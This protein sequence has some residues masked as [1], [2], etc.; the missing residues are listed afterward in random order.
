MKK[1]ISVLLVL[2]MLFSLA[3]CNGKDVSNTA[4]EAKES[5]EASET[6]EDSVIAT[7]IAKPVEIEF[8]HA[9]SGGNEEALKE[10]VEDFNKQN[11]KVTVK[12]VYQGHYKELFQKLTGAA[13]AGQ[14][15]VLTQIFPNRMTA[16]VMN[17]L[18][19][20]LTPY[21]NNEKVGFTEEDLKD[22]PNVFKKGIW[23]GKFYT[24]PCNKSAYLLFYN[25]DILDKYDVEVPTTWDELRTAAEKLTVDTDGDGKSDIIGV[26][27]NKS[28]G[29]D[30]SFWVEQ[31]GGHLI[32][33]DE[34]TITFNSEAGVEAFDF[35]S[36]MVKDGVA[37]VAGEEKYS[38]VPFA[39]GEAAMMVS[40][41]SKL[42][43][44]E[45][46]IGDNNIQWKAAV[47]PKGKKQAALFSGTDMA[48][49]NTHSPE[50]KLA[51]WEFMKYFMSKDATIKWGKNSGYLPVRYSAL[52]SE[53]FKNYL[54]ENPAKGEALKEFD[55]GFRDPKIL[56]GYAIHKNMQ[57]ALEAVILGEKTSKEALDEARDKARE[58][59]DEAMKNFGK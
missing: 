39:R 29:I 25:K 7:E 45:E 10:I 6:K 51:G 17:D 47:L 49:F 43:Y 24:M 31:A 36:G 32:S 20:D 55:Y 40:S 30:F 5:K 9:M 52:E 18:G 57:K 33:E 11:D 21:I 3:A 13:K 59:L 28:V 54:K 15:P 38:Y 56:N 2:M 48:M 1:I 34:K 44:L 46:A 50:E 58:E 19:E 23:D 42:P 26:G 41:T 4:N 8:W 27:F 12:M 14:L 35:V 16:Y 22:I 53:D 37:K